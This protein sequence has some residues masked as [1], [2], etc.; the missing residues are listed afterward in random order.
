MDEDNAPAKTGRHWLL[1]ALTGLLTLLAVATCWLMFFDRRPLFLPAAFL[2]AFP[3]HVVVLTVFALVLLLIAIRRQ[4]RAAVVLSVLATA[5]S[6]ATGLVPLVAAANTATAAGADVGP[7]EYLANAARLNLG[8]P[9]PHRT[10]RFAAPNGHGLD[11]DVWPSQ[12]KN[13]RAA[14]LHIHG[15][16]WSSGS[17]GQTPDWDRLLTRLG[18]TVFDIEYRMV[19]DVPTGTAWQATVADS[20]CALGWVTA[21]AAKYGIDPANISVLGQSAGGHLALMTAYTTGTGQFP[22]SCGG[23]EGKVKSVVS[24]YGPADLEAYATGPDSTEAG[25]SVL[26]NVLGGTA[27][28][29]PDRYRA[30]SPVTYIRPGMPRTLILQ[31]E[32]DYLVPQS[33]SHLLDEALSRAKVDHQ[34]IYLPYSDHAF[35]VAWGSYQTQTARSAVTTF[36]GAGR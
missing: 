3:F 12:D 24:F 34:A 8:S 31:G 28:E 27:A 15:G 5:L 26:T 32:R 4:R 11:L 22:S 1:T 25:R 17:R 6:L 23:P 16:G 18:F 10:V 2:R 20:K 35:D 30:F 7:G 36:L 9:D 21:N 19:G 33:Q 13:S 29:H 14:V